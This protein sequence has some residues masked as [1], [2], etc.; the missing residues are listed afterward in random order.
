MYQAKAKGKNT[1]HQFSL[2]DQAR[3]Q[4]ETR[5]T[6]KNKIEYALA[7]KLF[8]FHYQPIMDI[9]SR[10]VSHYEMLIRIENED[11]SIN[12]PGEFI[13]V[14][15]QTGL[16][17]AIDH[18]VLH[19]GIL[20]Q[21]E[22]DN[23]KTPI[24][25]SLNLSGHAFSDPI[26]LA[27]QKHFIAKN[28]MKP[29]HLIFEITETAAVADIHKAKEIMGQLKNIGC[30][31][32]IDDFGIGFSSFHYMRELPIDIVKIDG[33]FIQN[34]TKNHD[35][36]LFVKAL[37]DVAKGMGKKTVAEFV[38]NAESLALLEEFGVDYAQ[39]YYIGK[40]QAH[41]LDKPPTLK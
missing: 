39:G 3:L 17:H 8:I 28:A 34:I 29:E 10:T 19:Q 4:L 27:L 2:N 16:I 7:N 5:L 15:E 21:T 22:L 9:Q 11:G 41:F 38:E 23:N 33:S 12:F 6:W 24:S 37:V 40:P 25:L 35:D 14:A 20:K 1:W 18:Y 13:P 32:S 26:L 31:F 30:R 36:Q